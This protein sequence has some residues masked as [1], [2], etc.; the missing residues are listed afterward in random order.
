MLAPDRNESPPLLLESE[1][2][3]G[4]AFV[5]DQDFILDAIEDAQRILAEPVQPNSRR[6]PEATVNRL[7]FLLDRRDVVAALRPRRAG[8]G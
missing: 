3:C 7:L 1:F 5:S 2:S 8:Y 4:V 6:N